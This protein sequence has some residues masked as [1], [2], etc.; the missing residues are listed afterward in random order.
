M[1]KFR[2]GVPGCGFRVKR[3]ET[4]VPQAR[5]AEIPEQLDGDLPDRGPSLG[6]VR[7][8]RPGFNFDFRLQVLR[9]Q[10]VLIRV[11]VMVDLGHQEPLGSRL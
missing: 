10:P 9:F 1:G 5:A 4:W 3:L 6:P 7:F 2:L 11:K 8:V